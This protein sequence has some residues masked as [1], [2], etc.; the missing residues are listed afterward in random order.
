[1]NC[2]ASNITDPCAVPSDNAAGCIYYDAGKCAVAKPQ[3]YFTPK[4]GYPIDDCP[5]CRLAYLCC[6]ACGASTKR[7]TKADAGE[8][9]KCGRGIVY[10]KISHI[11]CQR[12]YHHLGS[13]CPH[14]G[15]KG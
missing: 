6:P 14:C 10:L 5:A 9:C 4:T 15:Q 12:H 1:M 11:C 8:T 3:R 13:T 7:Q 2:P